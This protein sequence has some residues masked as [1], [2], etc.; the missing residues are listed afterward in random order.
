MESVKRFRENS[1]AASTREAAVTARLFRQI[2]QPDT[3]YLGIPRHVSATRAYFTAKRLTSNVIVGDANF[4]ADDPDGLLFA[5][6]SSSAFITWQRTVGGK[7]KSDLRFSKLGVWNTFPLPLL[8]D[9]RR[10]E[11]IAAGQGVLDSRE[12]TPGRSLAAMYEPN[13]MSVPL[14][15]AHQALDRVMDTALAGRKKMATE[16]DRLAVLFSLYVE[17]TS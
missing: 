16:Q 1:K 2:S 8:S 10:T 4:L 9:N 17:M 3:E 5:V 11:L 15:K 14:I 13:A 7:I 6:I 12:L